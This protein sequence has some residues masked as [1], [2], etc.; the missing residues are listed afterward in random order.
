MKLYLLIERIL[1]W[2]LIKFW[3]LFI[4]I[5]E[6]KNIKKKKFIWKKVVLTK[7]QK[8]Q[9]DKY[10]KDNYGKKVSYKWH[11]L[12]TAY[13]GKFD[14]KY[15]PEYIYTTKLEPQNNYRSKALEFEDKS[16][17]DN[18]IGDIVK[19]PRIFVYLVDN[20]FY[21]ENKNVIKK[22]EVFDYL[23]SLKLE[24]IIIKI[25]KDSSSGR[26]VKKFYMNEGSSKF[27]NLIKSF[28]KNF[29]I[30]EVLTQY[31]EID[32]INNS[33]VN[34][35][36]IM[37]YKTKDGFYCT[38]AIMRI[39]CNG[40]YLDNAHAGG[41][42][43]SINDDGTMGPY[44]YNE[45]CEKYERH[46]DSNI[47]FSTI[48]FSFLDKIKEKALSIH[49]K[50][51]NLSFISYDF[52]IDSNGDVVCFEINLHSQSVWFFEMAHG[53]SFLEDNTDYFLNF[54]KNR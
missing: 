16:I 4:K 3:I 26:G 51:H 15:L 50:Y 21:D 10:Y 30:E 44:A 28:N 36:R 17:L 14:Y 19:T 20:V 35:I 33:S 12:Y 22:E 43:I 9:I 5:H 46:P 24:S 34:S 53:K 39:G 25:S 37:S 29:I 2:F 49:K 8:K 38:P 31:P 32:N 45:Y 52:M 40:S 41:I 7:E 27:Y 42:F 18:L 13:T 11:R 6:R 48:R 1:N 47:L 54:L 23:N